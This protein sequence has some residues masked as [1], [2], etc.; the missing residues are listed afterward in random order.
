MS[1]S[2]THWIAEIASTTLC[3]TTSAEL[4]EN[5]DWG[6]FEDLSSGVHFIRISSQIFRVVRSESLG[7]GFTLNLLGAKYEKHC[8]QGSWPQTLRETLRREYGNGRCYAISFSPR[9]MPSLPCAH[10]SFLEDRTGNWH[11]IQMANEDD[12]AHWL[13]FT[14]A[15]HLLAEKNDDPSRYDDLGDFLTLGAPSIV[16]RH[17]TERLRKHIA[18]KVVYDRTLCTHC[19]RCTTVC[20][21]M[22]A[23]V[24]EKGAQLLGPSEDFCTNCGLCRKR[25][26][27][28]TARPKEEI[29][30]S[31]LRTSAPTAAC[32][33]KD[34]PS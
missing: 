14:V 31:S 10:F 1:S 5:M 23:I 29:E 32:A 27:F 24:T 3:P 28:L 19:L 12:E 30:E 4:P 2:P 33:A 6:L 21:E 26:S 18:N 7:W 8:Q 13:L 11:L 20:N 25:C 16:Q 22:R 9:E 15:A 34:A 17:S